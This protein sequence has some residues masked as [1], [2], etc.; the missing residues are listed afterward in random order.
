MPILNINQVSEKSFDYIVVGGGVR[1]FYL[2]GR[3]ISKVLELRPL[4]SRLPLD[5]LRI[6]MYLCLS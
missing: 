3:L 5:F 4:A 1:V 6:R 2:R